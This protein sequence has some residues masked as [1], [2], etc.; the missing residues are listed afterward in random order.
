MAGIFFR[1]PSDLDDGYR[2]E[3][4]S[5]IL[6]SEHFGP[7]VLGQEFVNTAGLS[8]VFRRDHLP[9][10]IAHFP[11]LERLLASALFES[12]NA[13]YVNPL[14]L[15]RHSQVGAHV[16]CRYMPETGVRIL[17]TIVSVYYAEIDDAM[18]GGDLVFVTDDGDIAVRPSANDFLHFVGSARHYVSKIDNECR[19]VSV[20][21]EQYHLDGET[22]NAFPECHLVQEDM[23]AAVPTRN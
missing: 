14:V 8:L 6:G 21:I 3:M 13:F 18:T 16:D 1:Q 19:R 20:V 5:A 23:G 22:L 2:R 4:V 12:S 17:P 9:T 10:V 11:Y 15:D 7:S